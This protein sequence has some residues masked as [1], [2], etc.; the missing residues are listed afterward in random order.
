[1]P[2]CINSS[3]AST[4]VCGD[5]K[6]SGLLWELVGE[7][8]FWELSGGLILESAAAFASGVI[9]FTRDSCLLELESISIKAGLIVGAGEVCCVK[10]TA[11]CVPIAALTWAARSAAFDDLRAKRAA[12]SS[13][14]SAHREHGT[15]LSQPVLAW[16]QLRQAMGVF[17]ATVGTP[18]GGGSIGC[19]SWY[20]EWCLWRRSLFK[21]SIEQH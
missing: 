3:S 6:P 20:V 4:L 13:F 18:P 16:A 2:S 14:L 5:G 11:T 9:R 12:Q 15:R 17:P 8:F 1:L 21:L 10:D 19:A 7:L